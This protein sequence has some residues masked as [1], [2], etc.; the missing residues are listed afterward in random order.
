[1]IMDENNEEQ[2]MMEMFE[3]G[4]VQVTTDYLDA[5]AKLAEATAL[6]GDDPI[7]QEMISF[8]HDDFVKMC[9]RSEGIRLMAEGDYD[10]NR[11]FIIAE[12]KEVTILNLKMAEQIQKKLGSLSI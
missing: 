9:A 4:F 6:C 11:E 1:M 2:E 10:E 3:S 8:I 5:S 7:K 12:M